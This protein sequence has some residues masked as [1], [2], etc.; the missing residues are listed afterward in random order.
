[1]FKEESC[2]KIKKEKVR[3]GNIEETLVFVF[4]FDRGE[5][6]CGKYDSNLACTHVHV[7]WHLNYLYDF[8]ARVLRFS[9][10][11]FTLLRNF[12]KKHGM[13]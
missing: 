3:K 11:I 2:G 8:S 5:A 10:E 7:R 1:M 12:Y 9:Y 6:S 13:R 4:V